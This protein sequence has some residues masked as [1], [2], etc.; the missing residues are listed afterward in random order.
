MLTRQRLSWILGGI[1]LVSVLLRITAAL[2]VGNEVVDLPG[3]ADQVSYHNLA[4]RIIGGHGFTFGEPW[5]PATPPNEPTAHWSY[6][7]TGY[8]V[9]VYSLFGPSAL[10]ARLIQAVLVGILHPLLAYL[11]GRQV[12]SEAVGLVAAAL[13]AVYA[14]FIYYAANLM[15]EPFYITAILASLYLAIRLARPHAGEGD[16][17]AEA[18]D[19][20]VQWK[21]VLLLGLVLGA[22][23]LLRQ[24]FLLVV[25]FILLWLVLSGRRFVAPAAA[26]V[27]ILAALIL[28][29]TAFNYARF[30]RFVLLNTNAGFAFF[31]GNHPIYGT[32]FEPILKS[33]S[34]QSLIP[35][36]LL[37]LNEAELDSALL[38]RGIGF[39]LED[40]GRYA[41]L[42]L[43]RIPS[44]F[45]FWPSNDSGTISNISRVVSFGLLWPF[46]LYGLLV[47]LLRKRPLVRSQMRL[48]PPSPVVLLLVVSLVYTA[49]H[50]LTWTLVRYRLPVDAIFLMFAGVAVVHLADRVPG[51]RRLV[52][53]V[54]DSR[55]SF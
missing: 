48:L 42:S 2:Y 5:W 37:S 8:L 9:L 3:T 17:P 46:M 12:F 1:L 51:L 30:D 32:Q 38:Q 35:P 54:A 41:L 21:L 19:A 47:V 53:L 55:L 39:V 4:L 44:Y 33:T 49:V 29:F 20:P 25:P 50:I 26:I 13:T 24:L 28:P 23:V 22:A 43:S 34:Y 31:W 6:L 7:Y 14:Y 10:A 18:A 15:T 27:A 45:M 16:P 40:P 11:L 52:S 36:E